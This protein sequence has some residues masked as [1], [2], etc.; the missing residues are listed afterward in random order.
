MPANYYS[1][2]SKLE[3]TFKSNAEVQRSGFK[4]IAHP[5]SSCRNYTSIQGR[6]MSNTAVECSFYITAPEN[7]TVALYFYLFIFYE[8]DCTKSGFSVYE[9]GPNGKL[10]RTF[11][12]YETPQPIFANTNKLFVHIKTAELSYSGMYDLTYVATNKGSG[13]GGEIFNYGGV[14]TSPGYPSNDRNISDCRWDITVPQNLKVSLKFKDFN[15]GLKKDCDTDYVQFVEIDDSGKESVARQFCGDDTPAVYK[16]LTSKIVIK[17]M[18]TVNFA[19]LG[20]DLQFMGVAESSEI[21][22]Y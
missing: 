4:I 10:L 14:F 3:V 22:D 21:T 5:G 6:M 11:C 19:G 16:S 8:Q 7:Y 13:C 9:N 17:Y 12:G 20:W 2:G 1:S 18:R 15:M